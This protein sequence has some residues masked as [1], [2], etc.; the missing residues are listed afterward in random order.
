MIGGIC[1]SK[2]RHQSTGTSVFPTFCCFSK[3]CRF[4]TALT[5]TAEFAMGKRTATFQLSVP[6]YKE[7]QSR[8]GCVLQWCLGALTTGPGVVVVGIAQTP[9][10]LSPGP[11]LTTV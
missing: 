5:D 6:R 10:L 3:Y 11:S 4:C 8:F 1:P 9:L 7:L 2:C